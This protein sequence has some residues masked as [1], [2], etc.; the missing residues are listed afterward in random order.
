[1]SRWAVALLFAGLAG[2]QPQEVKDPAA[3]LP[4]D[5]DAAAHKA[6]EFSFNPV[7]SQRDVSVGLFYFKSKKDYKAAVQRFRD[8]TKWNDGNAEAW[9][10]L[11]EAE[12][13]LPDAK[14]A[15]EAYTKYLQLAP[16]AKNASEVKKR[17]AR[18]L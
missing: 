9:F 7:K 5:E 17:L 16:Q 3:E 18:L 8:A 11:G 12:A 15:R 6:E 4:P 2:A 13:K 1:M 14:A 10:W